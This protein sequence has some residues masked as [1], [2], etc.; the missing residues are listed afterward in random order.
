MRRIAII[1]A[2]M[3][4]LAAANGLLAAGLRVAVVDKGRS[5][6]GRIACRKV[7]G[8][9][10]DHGLR[11]FP[12]QPLPFTPVLRRWQSAGLIADWAGQLIGKPAMN[13]PLSDL[14]AGAD[15]LTGCPVETIRRTPS[16]WQLS[17]VDGPLHLAG[18][19][20]FSA[21]VLAIP[22][23]Q[24]ATLAE[25]AG[26]SLDPLYAPTYAPCWT[27]MAGFDRPLPLEEDR[28]ETPHETLEWVSRENSKP[29]RSAER[30]ALVAQA[31]AD[32][33]RRHLELGASEAGQRLWRL[34]VHNRR[35]SEIPSFISAHRWR[36]A[37]VEQA[38]EIPFLWDAAFGLGACGDWCMGGGAA[39]AF[40]SG[41]ALA[42]AIAAG[43]GPA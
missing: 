14:A 8:F 31:G 39:G 2:G 20:S 10:F 9:T 13:T 27:L 33:S 35:L 22:S 1:G 25:R 37:T 16:G 17:A 3:S 36:Y 7:E 15:L 21:V 12:P 32:W 43:L 26:L 40:A 4:G 19:G 11:Y 42:R 41:A 5:L 24:A 38:A 6:G 34:L 23:P 30:E 18:N 28:T 29:G